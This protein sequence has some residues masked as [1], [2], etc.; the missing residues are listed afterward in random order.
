MNTH[1]VPGRLPEPPPLSFELID[2]DIVVGWVSRREIGF[3][4]FANETDAANA[5]W[6]AHRTLARRLARRGGLRA[7]SIDTEPLTLEFSGENEW[8]VASRM[9]IASLLRPG[10]D[11]PSGREWFGFAIQMP[12]AVDEVG[13]RATA[14]LLHR[15]LRK[16]GIRWA[17]FP[18]PAHGGA[19]YAVRTRG[20]AATHVSESA[21]RVDTTGTGRTAMTEFVNVRSATWSP[22]GLVAVL[23]SATMALMVV[24]TLVATTPGTALVP[25]AVTILTV[26][27]AT[28]LV[29]LM[30][31]RLSVMFGSGGRHDLL[32]RADDASREK[33]GLRG[34]EGAQKLDP[35][36]DASDDS[37]PAS[38]PPSWSPLHAGP[39]AQRTPEP[40]RSWTGRSAMSR[41]TD[42]LVPAFQTAG[43]RRTRVSEMRDAVRIGR[44]PAVE[45]STGPARLAMSPRRDPD[46]SR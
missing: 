25:L 12:T 19:R 43:T 32:L 1:I 18:R 35:V 13:A 44:T 30:S 46:R 20:R 8:I 4:G 33:P 41:A 23:V 31:M 38:D 22:T 39:P 45:A 3:G 5:A 17:L 28:G 40:P 10:P 7:V 11:S 21:E 6:L 2:G 36:D 16:S 9:P 37:F 15:T 27:I 24:A 14:Y 42:S 26:A 29:A 34:R